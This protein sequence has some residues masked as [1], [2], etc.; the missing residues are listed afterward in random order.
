MPNL[1]KSVAMTDGGGGIK[2]K[3]AGTTNQTAQSQ[4]GNTANTGTGRTVKRSSE[5]QERSHISQSPAS[6]IGENPISQLSKQRQWQEMKRAVD[7]ATLADTP[8]AFANRNVKNLIPSTAVQET[9]DILNQYRQEAAKQQEARNSRAAALSEDAFHRNQAFSLQ[10]GDS[11]ENY[12][13]DQK[14]MSTTG[15]QAQLDSVNQQID[16][17]MAQEQIWRDAEYS[18]IGGI[19]YLYEAYLDEAYLGI[20]MP[21]ESVQDQINQL[22]IIQLTQLS[23]S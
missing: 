15:I 9:Q 5:G 4:T 17:L 1:T 3:K 23:K 14:D 16:T 12:L 7:H 8:A 18:K 21:T 6:L 13:N 10:Y 19:Q 20:E 11:Y 22:M 2:R